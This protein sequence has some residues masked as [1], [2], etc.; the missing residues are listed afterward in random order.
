MNDVITVLRNQNVI[1]FQKVSETNYKVTRIWTSSTLESYFKRIR[2]SIFD[3]YHLKETIVLK[4]VEKKALNYTPAR[5]AQK[6]K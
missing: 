4:G 3:I 2:L 6:S 5:K 1:C